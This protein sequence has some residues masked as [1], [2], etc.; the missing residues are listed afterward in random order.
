MINLAQIPRGKIGILLAT[1]ASENLFTKSLR[2]PVKI[3]TYFKA[4]FNEKAQI[5]LVHIAS[6]IIV[7]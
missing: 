6:L 4:Y 2:Q 5:S 3:F 7:L 1:T